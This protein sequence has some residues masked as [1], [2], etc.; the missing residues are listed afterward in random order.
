VTKKDP[1]PIA[2]APPN[3][4]ASLVDIE[5]HPVFA[6]FAKAWVMPLI[7]MTLHTKSHPKRMAAN[8]P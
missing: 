8:S 5:V 6:K 7:P 2:A 1:V 3:A 4:A